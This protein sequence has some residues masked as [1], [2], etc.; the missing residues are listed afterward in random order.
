MTISEATRAAIEAAEKHDLAALAPALDARQTALGSLRSVGYTEQREA[1]RG[2]EQIAELLRKIRLEAAAE[3]SR[4]N[5]VL[6]AV[7]AD[8]SG[9][10]SRF[11]LRA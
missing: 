10:A 6:A 7:G 5:Q 8:S 4:L 2:G 11:D 3:S 1:L 9:C